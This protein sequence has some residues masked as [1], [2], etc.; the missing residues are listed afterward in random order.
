[1]NAGLSQIPKKSYLRNTV[2][3]KKFKS[4]RSH[5]FIC[6]EKFEN[7]EKNSQNRQ[8]EKTLRVRKN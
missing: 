2:L 5:N 6:F 1:M 8:I 4:L 3:L 7:F